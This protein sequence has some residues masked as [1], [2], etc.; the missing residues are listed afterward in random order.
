MLSPFRRD[1]LPVVAPLS[2]S[3]L[4]GRGTVRRTSVCS[5]TKVFGHLMPSIAISRVQ[6]TK[7]EYT[8]ARSRPVP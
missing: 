3:P 7:I 6:S 4:S 8:A 1:S 5:A 2:I